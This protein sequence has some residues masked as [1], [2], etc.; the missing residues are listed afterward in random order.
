MHLAI[1]LFEKRDM[2]KTAELVPGPYS[3]TLS[4]ISL[5]YEKN[6]VNKEKI[7]ICIFK[8]SLLSAYGPNF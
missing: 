2:V 5:K 3:M 7:L 4:H 8:K 6:M 1:N